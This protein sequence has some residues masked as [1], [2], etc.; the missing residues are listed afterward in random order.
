MKF[1]GNNTLQWY[2]FQYYW[3]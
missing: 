3:K 1:R 2:C